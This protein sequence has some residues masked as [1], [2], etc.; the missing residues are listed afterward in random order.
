MAIR[1]RRAVL[2]LLV[3]ALLL[4]G[5][6]PAAT[7]QVGGPEGAAADW[8]QSAETGAPDTARSATP[9]AI[10]NDAGVSA[11]QGGQ[12]QVV[13]SLPAK[14][15]NVHVATMPGGRSLLLIA[16]SGNNLARFDAGTF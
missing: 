16:G 9:P 15:T 14:Y 8:L 5:T 7:A 13:G 1:C 2:V 6:A 11:A 3:G 10:V 4:G 12:W